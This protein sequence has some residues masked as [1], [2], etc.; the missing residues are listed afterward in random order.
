MNFIAWSK[1]IQPA[2]AILIA[3]PVKAVLFYVINN[4]FFYAH[5]VSP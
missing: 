5:S 4:N 1:I 2:A 3:K